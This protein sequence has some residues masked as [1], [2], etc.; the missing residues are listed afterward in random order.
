MGLA[1]GAQ[2]VAG[3][4]ALG[5]VELFGAALGP[6]DAALMGIAAV[7]QGGLLVT[8][9]LV[10]G[11]RGGGGLLGLAVLVLAAGLVS[12]AVLRIATGL[13]LSPGSL[14]GLAE[15]VQS[16]GL[17]GG[18]LLLGMVVLAPLGEELVFRGALW[19]ALEPLGPRVTLV[20]TSLCFSA[21]HFDPLHVIATLPL[22]F[23]LGWLR[24]VSG[25]I[26]ACVL[27]HFVNN[28]LWWVSAQ[29]GLQGPDPWIATPLA[30]A[31]LAAAFWR[32]R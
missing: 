14:D 29:I 22:A 19:R 30:L 8:L 9:G 4:T 17:V 11:A 23:F 20:A 7:V 6:Q 25:G 21:V 10:R 12:E 15:A 2:L 27:A 3:L 32:W 31:A 18:L 5:L 28:A 26:R 13:G 1:L 24:H 16:R